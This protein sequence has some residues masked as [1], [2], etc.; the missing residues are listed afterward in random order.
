MMKASRF[1]TL[2][3]RLYYCDSPQ[4]YKKAQFA[5]HLLFDLGTLTEQASWWVSGK[6][7]T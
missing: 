4:D 5:F 3:N 6:E 1:R 2:V 7:S